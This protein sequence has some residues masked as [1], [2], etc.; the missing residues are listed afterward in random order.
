MPFVPDIG[1]FH[2]LFL[3]KKSELVLHAFGIHAGDER[4]QSGHE[5][6]NVGL[7]CEEDARMPAA[8]FQ[9]PTVQGHEMADIVS[10]EHAPLAGCQVK[11][12]WV[13]QAL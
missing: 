8:C 13:I 10:Q 2:K 3:L 5:V 12:R 9:V 11:D 4:K 7:V 1:R 6:A